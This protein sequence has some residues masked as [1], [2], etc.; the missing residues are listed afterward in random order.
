MYDG[1]PLLSKWVEVRGP[2][3]LEVVI[4]AVEQLAVEADWGP[5]SLLN[6]GRD[7]LHAETD[8]AHGTKVFLMPAL[9]SC[10]I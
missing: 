2:A 4:L 1:L 3:G 8:Q 5:A 6:Q 9:S 10:C 7:W